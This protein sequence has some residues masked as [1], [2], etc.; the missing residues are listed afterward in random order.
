MY[1]GWF[2][3]QPEYE[4][5]KQF[6]REL[7][8]GLWVADFF[9]GDVRV[10]TQGLVLARCSTTWAQLQ[11]FCFR[12]FW[13]SYLYFQDSWDDKEYHYTCGSTTIE[14]VSHQVPHTPAGPKLQSSCSL[15]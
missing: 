13:S 8:G 15:P 5:L 3:S 4:D 6:C 11:P 10:W 7:E 14:I 2:R 9:F 1:L 12:Y